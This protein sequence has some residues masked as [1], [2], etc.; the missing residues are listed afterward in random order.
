MPVPELRCGVP[1][2]RLAWQ[3]CH[4]CTVSRSTLLRF[5]TAAPTERL[6]GRC[7]MFL[8]FSRIFES[9]S[10]TRSSGNICMVSGE[11]SNSIMYPSRNPALRTTP[12]GNCRDVRCFIKSMSKKYSHFD[13]P[14]SSDLGVVPYPSFGHAGDNYGSPCTHSRCVQVG[15]RSF[16]FHHFRR[17]TWQPPHSREPPS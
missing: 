6:C 2:D 3:H 17:K 11:S 5:L 13:N 7:F 4:P 12:E 16:G 15:T 14:R 9:N 10:V 8:H 1:D